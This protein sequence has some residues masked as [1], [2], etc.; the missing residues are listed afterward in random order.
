[1]LPSTDFVK[2]VAEAEV[3]L[4]ENGWLDRQHNV[5]DAKGGKRWG[6]AFG[7]P[8][9]LEILKRQ[10]HLTLFDSTH[11]L[12]R[13][14]HNMFSFLR[15]E[16]G[17]WIPVA[18]YVVGRENGETLSGALRCFKIWC[19]GWTPR[20]VMTD[21]SSIGRKVVRLA[22]PG[23]SIGEQGVSHLLCTVHSESTLK[24]PIRPK[25][26]MIYCVGQCMYCFTS[27]QCIANCE[28]AIALV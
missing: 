1:M 13:W 19:P 27:P 24:C 6:L 18:H 12:D 2:D 23:P 5:T 4:D 3:I 28:Q 25:N 14:K 20:Y 17:T 7:H 21:D 11:K 16:Q 15:D 22:F 9:R 8:E 26:L 10:G